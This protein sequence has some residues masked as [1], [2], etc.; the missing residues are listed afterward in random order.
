MVVEVQVKTALKVFSELFGQTGH[1]TVLI[2]DAVL[3]VLE[4]RRLLKSD[5]PF[6]AVQILPF[7]L[8]QTDAIPSL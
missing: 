1:V 7:V 5:S 3:A 4:L 6:L 2:D 8:S